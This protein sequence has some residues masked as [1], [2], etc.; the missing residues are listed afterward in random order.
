MTCVQ[1]HA[2]AICRQF[3]ACDPHVQAEGR[4]VSSIQAEGLTRTSTQRSF[5]HPRLAFKTASVSR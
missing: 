4:G 5:K 1:S 3:S 2:G